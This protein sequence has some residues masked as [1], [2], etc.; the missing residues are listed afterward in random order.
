MFIVCDTETSSLLNLE[1]AGPAAQPEIVELAAIKLDAEFN[2]IGELHFLC[3][4]KGEI[5]PGAIRVHGLD[6]ERLKNEK[7]FVAFYRELVEFFIGSKYWIGHNTSFDKSML[8]WELTRLGKQIN[9]PYPPYDICTM[10]I[11]EQQ[12]G[13]RLSLTN[14]YNELMGETFTDAHT[15]MADCKATMKLFVRMMEQNMVAIS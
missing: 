5:A 12:K 2:Q 13:Y 14:A 3:K 10:S 8:L 9:F 1:A 4:P 6:A 11:L 15:A 7:P